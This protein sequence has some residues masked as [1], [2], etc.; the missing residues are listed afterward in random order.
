[1]TSSIFRVHP[2][3]YFTTSPYNVQIMINGKNCGVNLIDKQELLLKEK[4]FEFE[5][6]S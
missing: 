5:V 4:S 1:M 2:Y 3:S 6:D